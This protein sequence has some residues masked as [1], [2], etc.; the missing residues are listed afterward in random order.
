MP[1]EHVKH[2]ETIVAPSVVEYVP[3]PQAGHAFG[4]PRAL[5]KVPARQSW[6]VMAAMAPRLVEYLPA[7]HWLQ[8]AL[9]GMPVP[10]WKVPAMQDRHTETAGPPRTVE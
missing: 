4:R 9:A 6:Q 1:E 10:V 5:E 3:A 7:P 8:L 2:V